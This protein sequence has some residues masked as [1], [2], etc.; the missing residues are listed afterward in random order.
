MFDARREYTDQLKRYKTREEWRK[1]QA[2]MRAR[3]KVCLI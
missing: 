1:M 3:H 2:A